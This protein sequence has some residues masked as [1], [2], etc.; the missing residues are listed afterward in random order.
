MNEITLKEL[1][2][3]NSNHNCGVCAMKT[4]HTPGPWS[5]SRIGNPYDQHMVYVEQT[6]RN[7]V[8]SCEGEANA[9]LIAAAPE[10]LSALVDICD[11]FEPDCSNWQVKN[12]RAAIAKA[13]GGKP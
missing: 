3:Q 12:A 5:A 11:S 7:I 6:G 10:L 4:Q 1:C 13:T 2:D 8:T 9:S